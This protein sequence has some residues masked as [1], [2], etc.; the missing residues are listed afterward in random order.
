MS[1]SDEVSKMSL[2]GQ[3]MSIIIVFHQKCLPK[4]IHTHKH[5]HKYT[6][7]TFSIGFRSIGCVWKGLQ[8]DGDAEGKH[9]HTIWQTLLTA[10]QPPKTRPV[11]ERRL[12]RVWVKIKCVSVAAAAIR[13][14]WIWNVWFFPPDW[15]GIKGRFRVFP[16]SAYCVSVVQDFLLFE[17]IITEWENH[18][19]AHRK[20]QD[21]VGVMHMALGF[22][23]RILMTVNKK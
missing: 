4:Y 5:T 17:L 1:S 22:Q 19:S 2:Q 11:M 14:E 3:I 21:L 6:H 15:L 13:I 7:G 8:K 12:Y 23:I 18:G 20:V 9:V 16:P 10:Q